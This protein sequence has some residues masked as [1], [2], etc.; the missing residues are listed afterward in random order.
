M[1]KTRDAMAS[2]SC[3]MCVES[4]MVLSQDKTTLGDPFVGVTKTTYNSNAIVYRLSNTL[5]TSVDEYEIIVY[6]YGQT[7]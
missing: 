4:K 6:F 5:L 2:T 1:N 7:V 3:K